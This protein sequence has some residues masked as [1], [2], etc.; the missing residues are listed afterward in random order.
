VLVGYPTIGKRSTAKEP[1]G[2]LI[3]PVLFCRIELD[4]VRHR[5]DMCALPQAPATTRP[6]H[7]GGVF[8]VY[9]FLRFVMAEATRHLFH[10]GPVQAE[11][12]SKKAARS[13][14]QPHSSGAEWFS[15]PAPSLRLSVEDFEAVKQAFS[16]PQKASPA[17]RALFSKKR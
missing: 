2:L 4:Y 17:L 15:E 13:K 8:G 11:S 5:Y 3:A 14:K 12:R 7:G 1:T 16:K 6:P 10:A 9:H